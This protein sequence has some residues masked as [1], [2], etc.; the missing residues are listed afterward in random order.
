M[1]PDG[2]KGVKGRVADEGPEVHGEGKETID[3]G[4]ARG[5]R[6]P[7]EAIGTMVPG[8]AD[9]LTGRGGVTGLEVLGGARGLTFQG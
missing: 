8:G 9:S 6:K 2:T 3:Q 5:M 1:E 7:G 4:S